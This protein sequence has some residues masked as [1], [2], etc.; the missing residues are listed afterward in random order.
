MYT[1]AQIVAQKGILI[2]HFLA[3][4]Y[5]MGGPHD[6]EEAYLY[7][8]TIDSKDNRQRFN[9]N[10][11]KKIQD[12]TYKNWR[13]NLFNFYNQTLGLLPE[14][15]ANEIALQLIMRCDRIVPVSEADAFS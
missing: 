9:R 13:N 5:A 8:E 15:I 10:V 7:S 11:Q 2:P 4:N 12:Y 3:Q 1:D 6:F 14:D